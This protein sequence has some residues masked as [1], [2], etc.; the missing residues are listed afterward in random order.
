[1]LGGVEYSNG[2]REWLAHEPVDPLGNLGAAWH[3]YNFN[4]CVTAACWDA[5]PG[6]VAATVP[7]VATE[8]GQAD[9][10]GSTFLKP[11]MN[12]LDTNQL[13]YLAWSWNTST[14]ECT[15][16][17]RDSEGAPWALVTDYANPEPNSEYAATFRDHIAAP[18]P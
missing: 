17:M 9:C 13:G 3:A 18:R 7:V 5:E 6:T 8:I 4:G 1:L 10:T 16:R 11:L 14:T 12:W 2:L 15:P